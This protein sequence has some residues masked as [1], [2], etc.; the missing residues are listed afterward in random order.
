LELNGKSGEVGKP[1]EFAWGSRPKRFYK[2]VQEKM[3]VLLFFVG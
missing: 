3:E 1:G 2:G